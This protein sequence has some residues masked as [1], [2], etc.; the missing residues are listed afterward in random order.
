MAV[1]SKCGATS[2]WLNKFEGPHCHDCRA[3]LARN[4]VSDVAAE[5]AAAQAE[6]KA[7]FEA[8]AARIIL[9]TETAHNLPVAERLDIVTA[10][11]VVGLHL[12]KDIAAGFRD[13]FGGRSKVMQDGLRDARHMALS[14][15]RLEA[16]ALGADAVVG[17]DL[18][19]SQIS[20]GGGN[21][22][23]LVASGTAVKLEK[24]SENER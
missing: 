13:V 2:S 9:T 14:E 12:F 4:S 22:L 23:F 1:C 5:R 18:D 8:A 17:I 15:I 21:M 20:T 7:R 10:E 24:E 3:I 11:V 19:Y 16:Q 6:D